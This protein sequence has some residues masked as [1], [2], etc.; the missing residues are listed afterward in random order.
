M[1]HSRETILEV[2]GS[3]KSEGK[4]LHKNHTYRYIKN[5]SVFA[6]ARIYRDIVCLK[7]HTHAK[8]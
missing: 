8:S 7:E 5:N 6:I 3:I 1:V 4:T 2:L